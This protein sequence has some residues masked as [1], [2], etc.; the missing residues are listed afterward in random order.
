MVL[1]GSIRREAGRANLKSGIF[2]DEVRSVRRIVDGLGIE[3]LT[4]S[5]SRSRDW[6]LVAL[7]QMM[8]N[9]KEYE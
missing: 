9:E 5:R 3:T 2:G 7:R 6:W 4:H 8:E 1:R